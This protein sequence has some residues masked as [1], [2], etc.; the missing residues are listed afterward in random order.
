MNLMMLL[1]MVASTEPDRLALGRRSDGWT[2]GRLMD[3]ASRLATLIRTSG[4]ERVVWTDIAGPLLPVALY[5]SSW[6][7]T[8]FVPVNYR[9]ADEPLRHLIEKQAPCL[10]I[11]GAGT[12]ARYLGIPG[13]EVLTTDGLAARLDDVE[14]AEADWGMDEDA[15]ALLLYT[16]GTSGDPKAAVLR[17]KHLCS[18]VLGSIEFLGAGE[19]EATLVTVPPYHIAGMAA[20]LTATFSGRRLVQ[21]ANF[22]P[23]D[24]VATARGE[25]ITHAMVVPTMLARI[26]SVLS[27]D[28]AGLGTLR[29][30]SYGGG[31]MP[32]PVIE[33]TM[34]LL[35]EV[36]FVNAYGLTETSSSIAILGPDDHREAIS[37]EDPAVRGR[38][39][40]VGMPLPTVEITIRDEMGNVLGPNQPGE[41]WVKGDQV[42]GEYL[43]RA[44]G[45][46]EGWFRT[47]DGGF[48]DEWGYLYVTGRLDDVIIRGGENLS[49]GEIEDALLTHPGVE[50]CC[51]LGL[52]DDEW[53]EVVCAVI[54]PM[55]GDRPSEDELSDWVVRHLRSS[56]RPARIVYREE[57]PVTDTGKVLRRVLKA[58][59]AN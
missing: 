17:Q 50:S 34:R 48:I 11:C 30:L 40:S 55:P 13:A 52:P 25:G 46:D 43:G 28:G 14:P 24:W 57:L 47:N 27:A 33:E 20:I 10:V 59:L 32:I 51:V 44:G 53:G 45:I 26:N 36:G 4:A 31:R 3:R 8:P 37:S 23:A 39:G 56:R 42:S 58:E 22:D 54:V 29:H 2:A 41:V 1:E 18:Y 9:L 49:P 15:I 16:S 19:D 12:E 5:G 35:P 38:L 7:G 6:A 21:L